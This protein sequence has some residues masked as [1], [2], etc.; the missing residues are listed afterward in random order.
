MALLLYL[1]LLSYVTV[2]GRPQSLGVG[3]DP[4]LT[5]EQEQGQ[6]LEQAA[7]DIAITAQMPRGQG[8]GK[9]GGGLGN[10]IDALVNGGGANGEGR[11]GDSIKSRLPSQGQATA[12]SGGER[13]GGGGARGRRRT[14]KDPQKDKKEEEKSFSEQTEQAILQFGVLVSELSRI[15]KKQQENNFHVYRSLIKG[16]SFAARGGSVLPECRVGGGVGEAV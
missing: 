13:G 7:M 6:D 4:T 10:I 1:W 15:I 11:L 2:E 14:T 12:R 5:Q 8:W 9:N 16:W 3:G